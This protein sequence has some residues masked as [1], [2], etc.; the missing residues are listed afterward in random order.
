MYLPLARVIALGSII[1]VVGCSH[2]PTRSADSHVLGYADLTDLIPPAPLTT[3]PAKYPYELNRAGINGAVDIRCLVGADGK[4]RNVRATKATDDQFIKPAMDSVKRWTF[5]PA[6][7]DGSPV[8]TEV[9]IPV[10]FTLV[11]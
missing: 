3:V 9:E 4:P 2:V 8:E 11:P 5:A 1:G 7:R 6:T 10:R